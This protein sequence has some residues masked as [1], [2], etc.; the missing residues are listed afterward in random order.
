MLGDHT[1]IGRG[2]QGRFGGTLVP[3]PGV[4]EPQ[5]RQHVQGGRVRPGVGHPDFHEKVMR[6]RLCVH[7][8]DHP[9]AVVVEHAGVEQFVL[10]IV[11]SPPAV[12]G[13]QVVVG[14]LGLRVVV[15][16]LQPRVARQRVQEPPVLL[17]VFAVIPLR[18]GQAEHPL[19][20]D[21]VAAVPQRQRH[22]Q[23]LAD[24]AHPRHPVLAPSV[25]PGAGMIVG[26]VVPGLAIRAV[27]LSHRAPR[28]L[29]QV[30]APVVPRGRFEQ[31]ILGVAERRHPFAFCAAH[32]H[33]STVIGNSMT[34]SRLPR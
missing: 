4:A 7:D 6:V 27:V 9:V 22:T 25:S 34:A 21:R 17:G 10:G 26:E 28:S 33:S 11:E 20:Q 30:G 16:P 14:E 29:R 2:I 13:H 1:A 19:L 32:P 5:V 12:L 8:V 24:I 15:A 31:P 23:F 18:T 3:R